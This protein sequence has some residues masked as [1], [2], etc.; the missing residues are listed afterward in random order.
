M[1]PAALWEREEKKSK[2]GTDTLI[3]KSPSY[4]LDTGIRAEYVGVNCL[5]FRVLRLEV[6]MWVENG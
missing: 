2:S 3:L 4:G 5:V 1:P 6:E